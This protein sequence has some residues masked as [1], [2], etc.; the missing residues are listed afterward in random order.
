VAGTALVGEAASMLEKML[1]NVVRV[2]HREVQVS[3]VVRC[4]GGPVSPA[5]AEACRPFV[6]RQVQLAKP[7]AVLVMGEVARA[8]LGLPRQ[9]EWGTVAGAPALATAHPEWL[10]KN[11]GEKKATLLHLQEVARRVG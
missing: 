7:R 8:L 11:P 6:E 3:P 5:E 4:A 10:L 1:L 9:G 2:D